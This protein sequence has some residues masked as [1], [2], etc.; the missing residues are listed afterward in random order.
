E[1]ARA[2]GCSAYAFEVGGGLVVDGEDFWQTGELQP[3]ATQNVHEQIGARGVVDLLIANFSGCLEL[4]QPWHLDR[5]VSWLM[6]GQIDVDKAQELLDDHGSG[7]LRLVD[8]GFVGG[9]RVGGTG[10]QDRLHN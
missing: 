10:W 5:E 4:H 6:R 1:P 3:T 2:F 7:D 8:N 9:L